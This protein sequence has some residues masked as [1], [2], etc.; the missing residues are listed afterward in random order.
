MINLSFGNLLHSTGSDN[1]ILNQDMISSEQMTFLESHMKLF[2]VD[3]DEYQNGL[4]I[5][6][7][8]EGKNVSSSLEV[9]NTYLAITDMDSNIIKTPFISN[10]HQSF[11]SINWINSTTVL[12]DYQN[13]ILLWN[14]L[15]NNIEVINTPW[16]SSY[17]GLDYNP[18]SKSF[19]ALVKGVSSGIN[20]TGGFEEM[21]ID[22]VIEFTK[23][24]Q[25]LREWNLAS[26]FN[27]TL[28]YENINR[29]NSTV[30]NQTYFGSEYQYPTQA[31][32]LFWDKEANQIFV[33]FLSTNQFM[34]FDYFQHNLI[35]TIGQ[36]G[37]FTLT[38]ANGTV[39]ESLW[40]SALD[41]NPIGNDEFL[42]FDSGYQNFTDPL[43]NYTRSSILQLTLNTTDM[44]ANETLRWIGSKNYAS[45]TFGSVDKLSNGNLLITFGSPMHGPVNGTIL[46][47]FGGAAI[48]INKDGDVVWEMR[49]PYF[50]GLFPIQRF[51]PT[52]TATA[53]D[54]KFATVG[55]KINFEWLDPFSNFPKS[56]EISIRSIDGEEEELESG[57][58]N[59]EPI[60]YL[61]DTSGLPVIDHIITLTLTDMA[62][63]DLFRATKITILPIETSKKEDSPFMNYV[64]FM[65]SILIL[66]IFQKI[67]MNK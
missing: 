24:G 55:D 56:Y 18:E 61:L 6:G 36:S 11:N 17:I 30:T 53:I 9:N 34:V 40:Y 49:L 58:W 45:T 28:Y 21:L 15:T 19:M 4:N 27:F 50:W 26:Y 13:N 64:I 7:L 8:M 60:S 46:E 51:N 37:N 48:E 41:L 57:E 5:L 66:I 42:V 52:L 25:I 67:K 23:S 32:N 44:T 54:A 12:T 14:V 39:V 33:N 62:D 29:L 31:N 16:P 38:Q 3:D 20:V 63:N 35:F 47:H 22:S 43:G 2:S 65:N 10:N 1:V 59:N